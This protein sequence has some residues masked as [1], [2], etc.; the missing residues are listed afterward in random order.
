LSD[1]ENM[2]TMEKRE[3]FFCRNRKDVQHILSSCADLLRSLPGIF[4]HLSHV[5]THFKWLTGKN[6][7]AN[8]E[9]ELPRQ[10]RLLKGVVVH[11]CPTKEFQISLEIRD[12]CPTLKTWIQWRSENTFSVNTTKMFNTSL[13]PV[14]TCLGLC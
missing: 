13:V 6:L 3:Q 9:K 8:I 12:F 7:V 2:D 11:M 14:L 10:F 1:L 4:S 5:K